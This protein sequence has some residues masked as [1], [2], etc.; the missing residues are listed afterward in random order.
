[1][2]KKIICKA[3]I[4]KTRYNN[5]LPL[6][7]SI[8]TPLFDILFYLFIQSNN[9]LNIFIPTCSCFYFKI[10]MLLTMN[11]IIAYNK[12]AVYVE[13]IMLRRHDK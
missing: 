1:M 2:R 9:Y 10:L 11:Y 13:I 8:T 3:R 4:M 7:R 12:N 5:F 6:N